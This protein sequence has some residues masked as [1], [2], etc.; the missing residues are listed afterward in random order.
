MQYIKDCLEKEIHFFGYSVKD[1]N[2]YGFFDFEGKAKQDSLDA[3]E[4]FKKLNEETMKWIQS[5]PEGVKKLRIKI[6]E[7]KAG[8]KMIKEKKIMNWS[9]MVTRSSI[10]E[11]P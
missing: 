6:N 5:D 3:F 10:K 7:D 11:P 2:K 8:F 1:G 4:G 9:D